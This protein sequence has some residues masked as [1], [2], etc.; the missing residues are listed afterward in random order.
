MCTKTSSSGVTTHCVVP[1][2]WMRSLKTRKPSSEGAY[3]VPRSHG[4][5]TQSMTV[6]NA[7]LAHVLIASVVATRER[8]A[9]HRIFFVREIIRHRLS[10]R[11][12]YFFPIPSCGCANMPCL[13]SLQ[14]AYVRVVC[15]IFVDHVPSQ[16]LALDPIQ[17][18]E[19][20][21]RGRKLDG[22]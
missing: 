19:K 10:E 1:L 13:P 15:G 2:A 3:E 18:M 22:D 20:W 16:R 17:I 21:F 4:P 5:R 9:H 12:S 7:M 6:T 8:S 14:P 11:V